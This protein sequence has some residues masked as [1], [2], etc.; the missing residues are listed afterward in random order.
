MA[1][2]YTFHTD[3]GH[4]WLEVPVA[5]AEKYCDPR[6]LSSYSYAS[7][8][9]KVLYLEEDCDAGTFLKGLKEN[10]VEFSIETQHTNEDH[11][12]RRLPNFFFK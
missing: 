3:P 11:W 12:I 6:E 10:G 4:G 1:K 2:T 5:D 8:N 7:K 9:L